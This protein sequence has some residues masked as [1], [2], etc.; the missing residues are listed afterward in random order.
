MAL[1]IHLIASSSPS[2]LNRTTFFGSPVFALMPGFLSTVEEDA[3]FDSGMD[4]GTTGDPLRTALR[5]S[6]KGL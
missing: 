4:G 6:A 2:G 3:S 1:S 5:A